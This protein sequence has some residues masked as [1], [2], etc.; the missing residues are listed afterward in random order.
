MKLVVN[1]PTVADE[2]SSESIAKRAQRAKHPG[3][4]Q[5][6]PFRPF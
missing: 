6:S 1:T 2:F 4:Q 3:K 5:A